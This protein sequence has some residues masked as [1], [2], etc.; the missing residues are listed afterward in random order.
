MCGI[1]GLVQPEGST[2]GPR[3]SAKRCCV[4]CG[5]RGPDDH[6]WLLSSPHVFPAWPRHTAA[7]RC[8]GHSLPSPAVD[9]RSD[10]SRLAADGHRRRPLLHRLQRRDLQ[11]PRAAG[12]A[13][14]SGPCVSVPQRHRGAAACPDRMGP[15]RPAPA[16]RHVRLRPAGSAGTQAAAGPRFLRHQAALLCQHAAGLRVRLGDQGACWRSPT[17]RGGS[18][19]SGSTISDHGVDRSWPGDDVRRRPPG[20]GRTLSGNQPGCP[21]RGGRA[22]CVTGTSTCRTAST[23]PIPRR[24]RGCGSCFCRASSCICAATC[25][26]GRPCPAASI[27]RPSSGPCGMLEPSLELHAFSYIADAT[28]LSEEKWVDLAAA[29]SRGRAAQ[30]AHHAGRAGRRPGAAGLSAG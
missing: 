5:H 28:E 19:R 7:V 16:D 24:R 29:A 22:R 18:I 2:P 26:S 20:A 9:P 11:L 10:R 6:G 8:R 3:R 25:R 27:R 15:R 12:R 23:F 21:G 4:C 30:G 14:K 17:C 1:A 13:G